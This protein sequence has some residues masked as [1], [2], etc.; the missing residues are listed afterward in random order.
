MLDTEVKRVITLDGQQGRSFAAERAS[1]SINI[2]DALIEHLSDLRKQGKTPIIASWSK[3]SRERILHV[4]QEHGLER[5]QMIEGFG[6]IENLA[7][8]VTGLAILKLE[9]GLRLKISA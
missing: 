5:A 9:S 1:S 6:E 2:Y 7:K 4:L 8:G 3:G